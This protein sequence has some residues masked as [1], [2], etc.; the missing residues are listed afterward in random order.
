[1]DDLSHVDIVQ[2]DSEF[3]DPSKFRR[4]IDVFSNLNPELNINDH[5]EN[6]HAPVDDIEPKLNSDLEK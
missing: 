2:R 6:S 3:V 5:Q 4:S 1:V